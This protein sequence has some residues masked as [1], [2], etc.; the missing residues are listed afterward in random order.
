MV[1]ITDCI[2]IFYNNKVKNLWFKFSPLLAELAE[3]SKWPI[4]NF[5]E[6]FYEFYYNKFWIMDISSTEEFG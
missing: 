1:K 2:R 5:P 3:W 4:C 6:K